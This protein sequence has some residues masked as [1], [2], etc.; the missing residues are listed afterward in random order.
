[1]LFAIL[2][3]YSRIVYS[4][5]LSL[6]HYLIEHQQH[7]SVACSANF[8]FVIY[9]LMIMCRPKCIFGTSKHIPHICI[10]VD[11]DSDT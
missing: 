9:H 3:S 4:D 1:M 11:T 8:D 7:N 6:S 5:C 10:R 2:F